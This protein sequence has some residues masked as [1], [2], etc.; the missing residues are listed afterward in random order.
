MAK[1]IPELFELAASDPSPVVPRSVA[2]Q[3]DAPAG[4]GAGEESSSHTFEQD[5]VAK[6]LNSDHRPSRL[7]F[8]QIAR[9]MRLSRTVIGPV[10]LPVPFF[11]PPYISTPPP[12]RRLFV[13]STR[14]MPPK[15]L[16]SAISA[17]PASPV[18][19]LKV[20]IVS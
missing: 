12:A 19:A 18:D 15:S 11:A 7:P 10:T 6:A 2:I 20:R 9:L 5:V 17:D 14:P 13:T 16:Y 4:S 1:K 3:Q 8:G